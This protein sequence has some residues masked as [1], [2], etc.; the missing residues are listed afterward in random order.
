VKTNVDC[1]ICSYCITKKNKKRDPSL[2]KE[3]MAL[4]NIADLNSREIE[5]KPIKTILSCTAAAI[6]KGTDTD[7]IINIPLKL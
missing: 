3:I 7:Q 2:S 1:G 4:L 5:N 6:R